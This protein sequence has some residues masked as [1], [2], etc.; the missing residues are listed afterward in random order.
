MIYI[1]L[2]SLMCV[3]FE[4]NGYKS[5]FIVS[6]V[7]GKCEFNGKLFKPGEEYMD[8]ENCELWT[9]SSSS[10]ISNGKVDKEHVYVDV[11]GCGAAVKMNEDGSVC[12]YKSTTGK[13]PDCCFG[14]L[15]CSQEEY[16]DLF[17]SK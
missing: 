16:N 5:L 1:F 10:P 9:C 7:D 13:Y 6:K 3:V 12:R 4:V 15:E 17:D 8:E 11:S 2:I 14:S